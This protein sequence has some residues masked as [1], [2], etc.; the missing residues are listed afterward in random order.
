MS[1]KKYCLA[2]AV[3][4]LSGVMLLTSCGGQQA[5]SNGNNMNQPNSSGFPGGFSRNIPDLYGEVKTV[6]GNEITV[7]LLEMPQPRQMTGQQRQNNRNRSGG[8]N[9][10]GNNQ[11]NNGNSQNGG[12]QN[13][14]NSQNSSNQNN[15]SNGNN[16]NQNGSNNGSNRS[17]FPRQGGMFS[18]VKKYTGETVTLTVSSD[19]PIST[20]G[21]GNAN[22]NGNAAGSDNSGNNGNSNGNGDNNTNGNN[23]TN[24]DNNANGGSNGN[25]NGNGN[26]N[27]GFRGFQMIQLQLSDIKAGSIIQ[28][29]YKKDSGDTKVVDNIRVIQVPVSQ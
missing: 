15:G 12:N 26:G 3:L 19:T 25:G 16:G 13:N 7:A 6:N 18:G 27:N 21:R 23:N 22:G 24:G 10:T 2:L 11:G 4:M 17:N 5:A 20:Y 28:V 29:W 9:Q 1:I 8:N 14:S